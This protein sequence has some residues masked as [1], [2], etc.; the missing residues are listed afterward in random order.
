VH[1]E[2]TELYLGG[3]QLE[4]LAG[5]GPLANLERLWLND[6]KLCAITGLNDNVRLKELYVQ[7]CQCTAGGMGDG[8]VAGRWSLGCINESWP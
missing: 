3:Q 4:Q 1:A 6:N 8:G 5:F 2:C 7:V